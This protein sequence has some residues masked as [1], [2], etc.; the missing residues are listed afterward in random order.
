MKSENK[1]KK[2]DILN[3][4][5]D[6]IFKDFSNNN[7]ININS[8]YNKDC[9]NN[10]TYLFDTK[11]KRKQLNKIKTKNVSCMTY[12][13]KDINTLYKNNDFN[14]TNKKSTSYSKNHNL[15]CINLNGINNIN[16]NNSYFN[17]N[18][19]DLYYQFYLQYI[20]DGLKNKSSNNNN[21]HLSEEKFKTLNNENFIK[22]RINNKKKGEI[23]MPSIRNSINNKTLK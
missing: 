23:I 10:K 13:D 9:Q 21:I 6:K 14:S 5:V 19:Q 1:N 15:T 12:N 3:E 22:N 4:S 7:S 17:N 2:T 11:N 8:I 20:S 18:Y 16:T